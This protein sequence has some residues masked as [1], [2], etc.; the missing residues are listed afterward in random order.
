MEVN[1]I[2]CQLDMYRG[3]V[4]LKAAQSLAFK[5]FVSTAMFE[6]ESMQDDDYLTDIN[7][8]L[9]ATLEQLLVPTVNTADSALNIWLPY[10]MYIDGQF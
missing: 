6:V 4:R 7:L 9:I 2:R 8:D 5:P 10:E 3:L 1:R